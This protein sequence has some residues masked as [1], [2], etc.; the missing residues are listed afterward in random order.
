VAHR[1]APRLADRQIGA[2]ERSANLDANECTMVPDHQPANPGVTRAKGFSRRA[3]SV[4]TRLRQDFRFVGGYRDARFVSSLGDGGVGERRRKQPAARLH[5]SLGWGPTGGG[6]EP[7]MPRH[8]LLQKRRGMRQA[9]LAGSADSGMA[10]GP[11]RRAD[12]PARAAARSLWAEEQSTVGR[13]SHSSANRR[14]RQFGSGSF[15]LLDA[16]GRQR[17]CFIHRWIEV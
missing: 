4:A 17:R 1:F 16:A 2:A 12:R 13:A 5:R 10:K 7:P 6:R 14:S 15:G 3:W 8:E 11:C 9:R